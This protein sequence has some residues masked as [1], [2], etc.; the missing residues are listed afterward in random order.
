[1]FSFQTEEEKL[2]VLQFKI[3]C[4]EVEKCFTSSIQFIPSIPSTP[5]EREKSMF[6]LISMTD[7]PN[8]DK[9]RTEIPLIKT[10]KSNNI[11]AAGYEGGKLYVMFKRTL[12]VYSYVGVPS[13]VA[14]KFLTEEKRKKSVGKFFHA[15]IRNNPKYKYERINP[16][17]YKVL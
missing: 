2:T 9:E 17:Y 15:H 3:C 14:A 5:V 1:M 8:R 10:E 13:P 12:D 6:Y 7:Y 16:E 4:E 11:L